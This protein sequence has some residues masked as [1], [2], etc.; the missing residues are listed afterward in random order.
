[1]KI[2]S[3]FVAGTLVHTDKGLVAI[4]DIKAGDKVLSKAAD[5]S[6]ELVYKVI[7]KTIVTEKVPVFLLQFNHYINPELSAIERINLRIELD[8]NDLPAPL[9]VTAN[10]PFWTTNQGWLKA[11]YLT[12]QGTMVANDGKKFVSRI[13]GASMVNT[14]V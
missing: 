2:N 4:Q 7:S 6:G 9:F 3:G 12:P 13:G 1:M 5:G 8:D 14:K 10:H 11:E